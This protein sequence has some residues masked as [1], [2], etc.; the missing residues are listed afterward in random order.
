MSGL[1][2]GGHRQSGHRAATGA[3]AAPELGGRAEF[4]P[5]RFDLLDV[6]NRVR[7]GRW[8]SLSAQKHPELVLVHAELDDPF[9]REEHATRQR[10]PQTRNGFDVRIR[11]GKD[12]VDGLF[13]NELLQRVREALIGELWK[14]ELSIRG[15]PAKGESIPMRADGQEGR[16][17]GLEASN[18]IVRRASSGA[19]DK[20][21]FAQ[22]FAVLGRPVNRAVARQRRRPSF[23]FNP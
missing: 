11:I 3:D 14:Q 7:H 8:K 20:N 23:V 1:T 5:N 6:V 4:R 15:G 9:A 12:Q 16:I 17:A 22:C 18:E 21:A 13:A 10:V 2:G 19:R